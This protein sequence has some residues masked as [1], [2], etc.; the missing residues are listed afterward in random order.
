MN[1]L[2]I[3]SVIFQHLE[4]SIAV[5]Y[6]YTISEHILCYMQIAAI[7]LLSLVIAQ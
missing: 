3:L 1:A 5:H 2:E 4:L 7:T 6:Q